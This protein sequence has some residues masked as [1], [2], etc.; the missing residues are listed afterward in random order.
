VGR[1]T[2]TPPGPVQKTLP[3]WGIH[4]RRDNLVSVQYSEEL[5]SITIAATHQS[6]D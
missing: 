5:N 1:H 2:H 4:L 3:R 6:M